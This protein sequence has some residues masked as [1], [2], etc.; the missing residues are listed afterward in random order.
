MPPMAR[1][2]EPDV[3]PGPK[4]KSWEC[5]ACGRKHNWGSRIRCICGESAPAAQ[6]ARAR[7]AAREAAA[8]DGGD[9]GRRDGRTGDRKAG[10]AGGSAEVL[11]ELRTQMHRYAVLN[12]PTR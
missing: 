2:D 3:L 12:L 4:G 11:K 6:V 10:S 5:S 7:K 8:R 9:G 1:R